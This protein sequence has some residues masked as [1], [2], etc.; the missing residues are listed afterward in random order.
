MRLVHKVALLLIAAA[1]VPLATAGSRWSRTTSARSRRRSRARSTRRR[2]TAPT[3]VAGEVE[4][5]ARQLAQTAAMIEW[6]KLS[7]A[8][9]EGALEIVKRQTHA[10]VATFQADGAGKVA[11]EAPYERARKEGIGAVVY[12]APTARGR[13]RCCR[14]RRRCAAACWR[15]PSRSANRPPARRGARRAAARRG[16]RR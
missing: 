7:P 11:I 13:S 8:E 5:R 9:L 6:N 3:V 2:G 1:V 12:S 14:R 15:W 10:R 16:A 4:G